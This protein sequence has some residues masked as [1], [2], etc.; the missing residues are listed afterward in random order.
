MSSFQPHWT[1]NSELILI[2]TGMGSSPYRTVHWFVE[3]RLI[4]RY[5]HLQMHN[6]GPRS[7]SSGV[8]GPSEL[9]CTITK[10]SIY[11]FPHLSCETVG[12]NSCVT[13]LIVMRCDGW[14]HLCPSVVLFSYGLISLLSCRI[15]MR[16]RR[17]GE[18]GL[19]PTPAHQSVE[20]TH[21]TTSCLLTISVFSLWF[22]RSLT[23]SF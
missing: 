13:A 19:T 22:H 18:S 12:C 21:H 20:F 15:P 16:D 7:T 11:H 6:Y 14:T 4:Y 2:I 3:I 17:T 5:K 23:S 10:C 9:H 8:S 1:L